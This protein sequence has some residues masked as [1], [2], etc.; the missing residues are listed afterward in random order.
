MYID[1]KDNDSTGRVCLNAARA[2]VA[3]KADSATK[4]TTERTINGLKFNGTSN[5]NNYGVCSTAA[6]TVAK[7]VTVGGT[8]VLETGAFVIV[9]FDNANSAANPTLNVNGTGAKKICQYG[10]TAVSTGTSTTGWRAGSVQIFV[11]DGANWI[12]DYW[13]NT[14]YNTD[15]VQCTTAAATAAKVGTTS[16]YDLTNSKYFVVMMRYANTY[17][18]PI[19]LNISSKGAKPIYINGTA[20]SASNYTLPLGLYIVYYDGTNYHFR[21][22]GKIPGTILNADK[23]TTNAGSATNPVYFANGIPVKTTYTLGKSVPSD[24]KF[25]DTDT[26]VTSVGNHYTPTADT[27]AA[28]SVDAS[29][30]TAATWNSTSLVTGVNLQRDA[31]GHVTGVTVDSI[32]M[33]A[34]PNTN[35]WKANSSSSEGYVAS[36]SGQANKVWKTDASG[37]PAWRNDENTT[38]SAATTSAAGLMSAADKAKLDGIA[39]GATANT[40]DITGVTAGNGLTGGG[41]SGSVTLNVGA[42]AGLTVAADSIGHTNSVTAGTAKGSD[43]KTLTFGGTFTLPSI[44]YDAQGHI[45]TKG[46]T[47]MTMPSDRLFTTLVP[48][49]TAIP[50]NANLNTPTYMKVGRYFCSKTVDAATLKNCPTSVA[51][52]MEVYSPL[53]TTIDN[54]T[55]GTWVYRIRK[56]TCYNTGMQFIQYAS[57]GSTAN[58]WEYGAWKVQP[59]ANF[60]LD[61]A[62]TNGGSAATGSATKPIYINSAGNITACTYELNKTVPADAE[63]TDTIYTL[64]TASSSTL[65]GVKIG[66]NINISNGAISV[67]TANQNTAGVTVVHPA[68]NCTSF[69]SDSGAI[70]PLAAQKSAELFAIT[71]PPKRSSSNPANPGEAGTCTTNNIVRWLN[72]AGDVQDSKITIEDVTNTRDT[73]KK[74]QVISIPAEDGKKMVY[75]YCTD[76]IDGTSFI[77]GVFDANATTYPY[78]QGLAIGGTSG[79]LLWKGKAVSTQEYVDTKVAGLVDS[80]PETLNTLNELAAALGDDENFATTVATNI[81]KKADKTIKI[82][83]GTGLTGGGDLS[84]NRT[85]SLATSGVTAGTYGPSAN[86]SGSGAS[87]T[88]P[89][90]AIDAYGRVTAASSKTYTGPTI[91]SAMNSTSTNPVQ[92]KVIK[93]Y[94]DGKV[95]NMSAYLPKSAGEAHKLTG[96]L[97]LT[98]NV[99]YGTELP[100]TGFDGQLF[101]LEDDSVGLPTG[102][103]AGHVLIKNSDTYGD[104]SWKELVALPKGG[105]TG[106]YLVKNSATDGDASW[107]TLPDYDQIAATDLNTCTQSGFYRLNSGHT[108]SC[109]SSDWGQMLVIHG[110]GDT[111]TQ[112]HGNFSNGNL[113]TRSGN[114]SDVGGAGDWTDWKQIWIQGNSVTGAVW[115]DYAECRESDCEEFGYV[116]MENGDDTLSKTTERLSHF[117]GISSDTW[118]FSQG[119]TDKAKTPIAVAGRVLAYPYQDR[120]NYKPGDC[121]CAAPG[122]TVDIMT[123][124]EIINWP[125]RIVG[126]VSCVPDY[127]E[128]GGGKNADRDSVKVNGRIWIKVR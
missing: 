127:E 1:T 35:T 123:R 108:N 48:T 99:M 75:G 117:A 91:D 67:P 54:E 98:E 21:T 63:F 112:I 46:T 66:N 94:I 42:G 15:A 33:P 92:N 17:Q 84:Q 18:G 97:G 59:I 115:N 12:R 68:V 114:S 53:S 57:V 111:I 43:T 100:A 47:T 110:G 85:L 9:K 45:T 88:I 86:V 118:G 28:L 65:G 14:T 71:R 126:T 104:A 36:G 55:T 125:D 19:T 22:D 51:F 32:K 105:S 74:A 107:K 128:W 73:T 25:T 72:T 96:A 120:D 93:A 2:D 87:I 103:N 70:T 90:F 6:A 3:T 60:T 62:D 16:Y 29:S 116:L 27:A 49:G 52:M 124:E 24:A 80:A 119:E 37:N 30:T 13:S 77:G 109:A 83:A 23:L 122:G 34:N 5:I 8:F 56:I 106:Q 26:K 11:Y 10:S 78:N 113:H 81:G 40:G 64:P 50:A 89:Q 39:T 4:L 102:G 38:Y 20:S 7:T 101:F 76:Q 79:N 95:P 121:V 69:T 58:N 44:T 61:T 31:K 41:S 82:S